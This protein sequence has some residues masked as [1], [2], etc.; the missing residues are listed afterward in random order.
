MLLNY[1]KLSFR[2]L[3]RNPLFTGINIVGLAIG[4]ASFY[5]LW[6]HATTELKPDNIKKTMIGLHGWCKLGME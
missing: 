5:A 2:L 1:L 6:E 4:V 3:A